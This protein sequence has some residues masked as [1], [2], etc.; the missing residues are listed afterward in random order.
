MMGAAA[1]RHVTPTSSWPEREMLLQEVAR[2][3]LQMFEVHLAGS[4]QMRLQDDI[5]MHP[6]SHIMAVLI[7][8]IKLVY[9][10]DSEDSEASQ[11]RT[12]SAQDWQSWAN[13]VAG[14]SRGPTTYPK[15][16]LEV[17]AFMSPLLAR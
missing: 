15:T 1:G 11:D 6:Y 17:H 2:V 9:G 7:V 10:L 13:A 5:H 12:R 4:P 14:S 3:A 16:A 8:A